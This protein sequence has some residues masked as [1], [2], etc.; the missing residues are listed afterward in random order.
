MAGTLQGQ[1]TKN[2]PRKERDL[3]GY[4]KNFGLKL[5]NVSKKL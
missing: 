2:D 3:N 5:Q 1:K 4:N